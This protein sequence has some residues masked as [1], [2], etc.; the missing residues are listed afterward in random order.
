MDLEVPGYG[1]LIGL[2]EEVVVTPEGA[3]YLS[4]PQRELRVLG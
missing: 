3:R 4:I 1:G 2:E